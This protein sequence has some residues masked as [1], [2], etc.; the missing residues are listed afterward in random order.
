MSARELSESPWKMTWRRFRK[1]RVAVASGVLLLL[2]FGACFGTPLVLDEQETLKLNLAEAK[3]PPS[4]EHPFGT[5]KLGR[6]YLVRCLYGGRIS[7]AVG[8][9]ATLVAIT[10]G[11]SLGALAG[12][13]GG[14]VDNLVMRGVD[15]M[16]AIPI[17]FVLLLLASYYGTSL[18][19]SLIHI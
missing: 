8:L 1:H 13:Q 18:L 12:W 10:V 4:A 7:L 5:T 9:F 15:L 19:L 2:L 3:Q 6:D 16:L 17:F 11:T 14:L